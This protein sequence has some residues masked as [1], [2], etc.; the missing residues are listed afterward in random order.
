ML[1]EG[2]F[3]LLPNNDIIVLHQQKPHWLSKTAPIL[4]N[5]RPK[6]RFIAR[7]L[8]NRTNASL[9]AFTLLDFFKP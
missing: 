4:R 2:F 3:L 1:R 5:M 9:H 7:M 6:I 8:P